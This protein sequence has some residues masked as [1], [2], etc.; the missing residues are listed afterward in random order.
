MT[1]IVILFFKNY[2]KQMIAAVIITMTCYLVYHKIYSIGFD[3]ANVECAARM[4]SYEDKLDKRIANIENN[5]TILIETANQDKL[6]L[7]KDYANILATIKGKPLYI[8]EQGKCKP[9]NLL[10]DS[11]NEGIKKANEVEVWQEL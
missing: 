2:W 6:A 11:Y 8:I 10:I 4:K 3:A 9:A 7:R 5:S 1:G